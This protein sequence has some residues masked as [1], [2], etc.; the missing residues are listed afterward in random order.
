MSFGASPAMSNFPYGFGNGVTI[1][2][3][4]VAQ[5]Q[6]GQIFWVY[7]GT[8][9][10]PTGRPGSDSN[11]GTFDSPFA[12][13]A[14]ALSACVAGRGDIIMVKPGHAETVS[15]AAALA[16]N[17]AG[18]Q[19]V[20]LGAGL[21]RPQLTVEGATAATINFS[22]PNVTLRNFTLDLTGIDAIAAGVTIGAN[23]CQLLDCLVSTAS[24][25]AQATLG[26]SVLTGL[27]DVVI[28]GNKFYGT[29]NAG[30]TAALQ[31]VGGSNHVVA[32]N[33][34]FGNYTSGTGAISNITTASLNLQILRN[35][36]ANNTASS[37]KVI[38]CVSG[39]TGV[40]ADNR[41]QILSGTAPITA[42]GM[43]WVGANYYANAV[44][45]AG[46]LI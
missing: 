28:A 10:S 37:T 46:T 4:P 8:A 14:G 17:V 31:I 23:G 43:S 26:V 33:S 41:M 30:T 36:L 39:T 18:V 42:A 22:A 35:L 19:I 11:R 16:L 15:V 7:N 24:A 38:T 20:G 3:M 5:T 27:L 40:I 34:F 45:T 6:G 9:L 12:T 44:A 13:I 21:N 2:N 1:R 25:S 32:E 29:A